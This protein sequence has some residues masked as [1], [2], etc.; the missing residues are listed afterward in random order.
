MMSVVTDTFIGCPNMRRKELMVKIRLNGND[1]SCI[2]NKRGKA[3]KAKRTTA[4]RQ[5]RI[6]KDDTEKQYSQLEDD[7]LRE[8]ID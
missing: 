4:K 8:E 3:R 5:R 7:L 1:A 2:N 6:M